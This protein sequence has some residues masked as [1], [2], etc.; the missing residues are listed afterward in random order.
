MSLSNLSPLVT[1]FGGSGFIGR[2]IVQS[3]AHR[4]YR[5]KVVVRKPHLAVFLKPL[6]R[7]GQLSIVQGNVCH[8]NSVRQAIKGSSHVINCVGLL[9]ETS[10]NSFI[11]VQEHGA[12]TIAKAAA[13][14]GVPLTHISAIGAD[15]NSESKYA[16]SKGR[17]E[18]LILSANSNTIIIRPSIVFGS[19]DKFFNKFANMTRFLPFI[20]LIDNGRTKLQPVYVGDVAEV[21]ASSVIGKLNPGTIYEIG[22]PEILTFRECMEKIFKVIGRK[23]PFLSLSF[24][25]SALISTMMSLIPIRPP[26]ITNDQVKL[27]KRDNIVSEIAELEKRTL[28]GIGL[29]P[30]LLSSVLPSYLLRYRYQGQFTEVSDF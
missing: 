10:S 4:G 27:L 15:A 12:H 30:T 9:F 22:G 25:S 24:R 19:E 2:R 16:R 7:V 26:L 13:S 1:I 28:I 3:L 5:I 18:N 11:S 23:K 29:T 14:F 20:P 21:I 6:C 17:G 8:E